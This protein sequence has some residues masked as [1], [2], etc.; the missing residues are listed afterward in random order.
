MLSP[1]LLEKKLHTLSDMSSIQAPLENKPFAKLPLKCQEWMSDLWTDLSARSEAHDEFVNLVHAR[2]IGKHIDHDQPKLQ[3]KL[4]GAADQCS[5]TILE[6]NCSEL[7]WRNRDYRESAMDVRKNALATIA[8][9]RIAEDQTA[10]DHIVEPELQKMPCLPEKRKFG[11]VD[12][13]TTLGL[14]SIHHQRLGQCLDQTTHE[15]GSAIA[16]TVSQDEE[17]NWEGCCQKKA[18]WT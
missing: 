12:Q 6:G 9:D 3:V 4:A 18:R 17:R 14:R 7:Y 8:E 16:L 2:I 13:R 11:I 15:G 10:K 5:L 1:T